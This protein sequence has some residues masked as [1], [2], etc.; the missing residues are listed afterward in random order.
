MNKSD[1]IA[2]IEENKK[3]IFKVCNLYCQYPEDKKDLEQDI[4]YQLWKSCTRYDGRV[5]ESTWIYRVA[6]NTAITYYRKNKNRTHNTRRFD[7]SNTTLT[8]LKDD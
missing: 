6:L 5:K 3:L 1:F 7:H 2:V 8:Y 4:L